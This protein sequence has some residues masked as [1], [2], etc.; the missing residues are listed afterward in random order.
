MTGEMAS[1]KKPKRNRCERCNGRGVEF[2]SICSTCQ[3]WGMLPIPIHPGMQ[4]RTS[5]PKV[6]AQFPADV[7]E[8]RVLPVGGR[9]SQERWRHAPR[10]RTARPVNVRYLS[11]E[12]LAER[13][14]EAGL[15]P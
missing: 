13:R 11:P 6:V 12:Q 14:R 15:D 5:N 7:T 9:Q 8:T 1:G 10:K 3:G 4:G 2:N